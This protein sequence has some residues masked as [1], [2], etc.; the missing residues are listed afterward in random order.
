[1][2]PCQELSR[3][4]KDHESKECTE[5]HPISRRA[6]FAFQPTTVRYQKWLPRVEFGILL[7]SLV[8]K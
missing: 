4:A 6:I 5:F 1:M 3:S 2:Q 8:N 7:T